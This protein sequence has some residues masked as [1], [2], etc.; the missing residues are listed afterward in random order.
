MNAADT[1]MLSLVISSIN[2][3]VYACMLAIHCRGDKRRDRENVK[4]RREG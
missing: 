1:A 4:K 2:S 3:V